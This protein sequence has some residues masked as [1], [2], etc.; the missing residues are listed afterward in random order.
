MQT[1]DKERNKINKIAS[2]YPI[3]GIITDLYSPKD[4]NN[5][6][7][8]DRVFYTKRNAMFI[9]TAR[10]QINYV[11]EQIRPFLLAPLLQ[12]ASVHTN[13]SGVFKGFYKNKDGIGQYG[14]T[15]RNALSRICSPIE[16]PLLVLSNFEREVYVSQL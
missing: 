14:G 13:T 9:D 7:K 3:A 5:I 2:Q 10:Q 11:D 12:R 6:T 4:E 15:M 8:E 1:L 16:I